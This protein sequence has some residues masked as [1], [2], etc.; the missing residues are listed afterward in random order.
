MKLENK[1]K[2]VKQEKSYGSLYLNTKDCPFLKDSSIDDEVEMTVTLKIRS[3][4]KPDSW[5]ISEKGMKPTDI[6]VDGNIT[7]ISEKKLK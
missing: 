3:L 4:R 1:V 2:A 6:I 7:K 5:D